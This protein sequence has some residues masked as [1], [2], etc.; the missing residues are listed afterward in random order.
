MEDLVNFIKLLFQ[1]WV[2]LTYFNFQERFSIFFP[3]PS[4][5][6]NTQTFLIFVYV[7][8]WASI[9]GDQ[10]TLFFEGTSTV[11]VCT[12]LSCPKEELLNNN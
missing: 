2:F 3:A 8:C 5:F 7:D 11:K 10:V 6:I 12:S 1:F 4:W 9:Y